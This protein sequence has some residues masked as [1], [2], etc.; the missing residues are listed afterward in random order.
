[1][2]PM[3]KLQV[4]SDADH[5]SKKKRRQPVQQPAAESLQLQTPLDPYPCGGHVTLPL[6][7]T[8]IHP[9]RA[10]AGACQ[11][12]LITDGGGGEIGCQPVHID[13]RGVL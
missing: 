5:V 10:H 8:P 1:M 7:R 3:T 13:T 9:H 2:H 12:V 6:T 4:A 11:A